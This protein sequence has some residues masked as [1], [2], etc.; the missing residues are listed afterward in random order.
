MERGRVCLGTQPTH[1]RRS[2][3]PRGEEL[4]HDFTL[5]NKLNLQRIIITSILASAGHGRSRRC[6]VRLTKTGREHIIG[7]QT[8]RL[9][10]C[11]LGIHQKQLRAHDT[12]FENGW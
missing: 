5:S 10:Q 2:Q 12:L 8:F 9:E 7:T 11:E 3:R 6:G 1:R 4:R